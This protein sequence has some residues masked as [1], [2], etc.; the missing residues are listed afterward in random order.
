M[1]HALS[2]HIGQADP[3]RI[4]VGRHKLQPRDRIV[5]TTDGVSDVLSHEALRRASGD[6]APGAA[7][8]AILDAVERSGQGDDATAVV[9]GP[10]LLTE[11]R[12]LPRAAWFAAAAAALAVVW[13]I[14]GL[15]RNRPGEGL[16]PGPGTPVP[17]T[18]AG[19]GAVMP[20][21]ATL[22]VVALPVASDVA[23]ASPISTAAGGDARKPTPDVRQTLTSDGLCD[24]MM[25]SHEGVQEKWLL[26]MDADHSG[27]VNLHDWCV[28]N[29]PCGR[30]GDN[31]VT[32]TYRDRF[33]RLWHELCR[34][35]PPPSDCSRCCP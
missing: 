21:V 29:C 14:V 20:P 23:T 11:G 34:N 16:V 3:V 17:A 18:V 33:N 12:Q 9:I 35:V 6:R 22:T 27:S 32:P 25:I 31:T 4:D 10:A 5:L 26:E 24:A 2:Q 30:A 8:A 7:I 1:R 19:S 13:A 15:A 28:V